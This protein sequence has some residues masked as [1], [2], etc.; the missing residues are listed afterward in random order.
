M[1]NSKVAMKSYEK[2][3]LTGFDWLYFGY[4]LIGWRGR[5]SKAVT[6]T[7]D[8]M[9]I[10]VVV[11][12]MALMVMMLMIKFMMMMKMIVIPSLVAGKQ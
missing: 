1:L 8:D 3:V 5:L 9:M 11:I 12:L 2:V 6:M 4:N 7:I 10:I